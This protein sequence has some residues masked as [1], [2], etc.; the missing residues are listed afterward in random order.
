MGYFTR[1][2]VFVL[3]HLFCWLILGV[4]LIY[5]RPSDWGDEIPKEYLIKQ[6]ILLFILMAIFYMNCYVLIP[7]ILIQSQIFT[8]VLVILAL[9]GGLTILTK[10]INELF[11]LN[12]LTFKQ[13]YKPNVNRHSRWNTF[14]PGMMLLVVGL[15]ITIS[16]IQKWQ[17]E[18]SRRQEL[19]R[20]KVTSEL[21][22]LKAQINPHFFF[23]T[24]NTIYSYTLSDGDTAR[25]AITN[26]S[27]MMRYVLYDASGK[28]TPVSK[29]INFIKE[30]VTLMKLRTGEKTSVSLDVREHPGN[31]LIAPMLFLPFVENAFKHGVSGVHQ[32]Y[33]AIWI[34]QNADGIELIVRNSVYK[35]R[36]AS[37]E[38]NNGIGIPNTTRRL[39]LLYPKKYSLNSGMIS[40]NEFEAKLKLVI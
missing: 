32:G 21:T 4:G 12:N 28:Q 29:E 24:L 34:T 17:E 26:L 40:E 15:S 35:S 31:F 5:S 16:F 22:L 8:Y 14:V 20:E 37:E 27:K 33:I 2:N 9:V 13:G 10:I 19:E 38:R 30:Y 6:T 39:D 7:K 36:R 18:V 1:S 11:D 23:N 25:T 3:V